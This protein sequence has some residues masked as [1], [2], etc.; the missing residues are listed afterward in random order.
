MYNLFL[1]KEA[2]EDLYRIYNYGFYKFG[3]LQADKYLNQF[4]NQFDRIEENPLMFPKVTEQ[5][6]IDRFCVCGVDRIFFNILD[7][8]IEIITIVGRQDF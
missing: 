2:K 8:E 3:E 5:K 6:N 4:Y 1:S 7:S